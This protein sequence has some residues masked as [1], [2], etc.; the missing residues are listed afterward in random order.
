[1]RLL[2]LTW[3]MLFPL[4]LGL[5]SQTP[6]TNTLTRPISL[7]ESVEMAL[8]GNLAVEIERLN[9]RIAG[10]N[11]SL[12]YA[13]Y[14]PFF[15][16]SASHRFTTTPS[17]LLDA[18]G[19]PIPSSR[20]DVDS[21]G[22]GV[23]GP[24]VG[25]SGLLPGGL[26]YSLSANASDSVF[27]RPFL[28]TNN[29]TVDSRTE[30]SQG[31]VSL[32][33]RQPVLKNAW[34]DTTR[35]NIKVGKNRLKYSELGL[36]LQVMN[37]VN[38]VAQ[39]YY[40]LIFARENI[41]VQ[42]AAV[43]LAKRLVNENKTR[44][45]VGTMA[46]LDEKQA[47]SQAASSQA[48]L[49]QA[50]NDAATQENVLKGLLTGNYATL[51][52]TQLVPTET[53][54]APIPVLNLQESWA[55][56]MTL[57]PD[58]LQSRLELERLNII[59]RYNKNQ[60]FPELDLIGSYSFTGAGTEFS[61]ALGQISSGSNPG[62][63]FG[64]LLTFPLGNTGARA[65]Y[66]VTGE[67]KRQALVVS[68]ALERDILIQID[69]AVKNVGNSFERVDATREA[70]IFAE[71]A[72]SAEQKKLESGKSTSFQVLQF[73]RDLTARRFEEI[74]ALAQ[75]NNALYNLYFQE[76]SILERNHIKLELK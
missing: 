24:S 70:R 7:Q 62:Y 13:D 31:T 66:K 61:G 69:N 4:A 19:R 5:Q 10:Y 40:G 14:D 57:R 59:L 76:G 3:L 55:K 25:A 32:N 45:Q 58:L 15:S 12:A 72:L 41:K 64:A 38:N 17:G 53:L 75:Y 20:S 33:L 30:T 46:P 26:A 39:A 21:V 27:H 44:V 22:A 56:G 60:L 68:K 29:T 51:H 18:Q 36:R 1:M 37:V 16:A 35:V 54:A 52:D 34:V 11:V 8:Q 67:Q 43:D 65:A 2:T 73:Q 74:R 6:K 48:D 63:S 9:T 47:E 42:Q 50:E 49:L 23:G 28:T 71:T